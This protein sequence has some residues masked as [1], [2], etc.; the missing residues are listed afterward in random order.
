MNGSLAVAEVMQRTFCM[1]SQSGEPVGTCFTVEHGGNTY[2]VTAAHVFQVGAHG[3]HVVLQRRTA[4]REYEPWRLPYELVDISQEHDMAVVQIEPHDAPRLPLADMGGLVLG[5]QCQFFGFPFGLA[6]WPGTTKGIHPFNTVPF[7]KGATLASFDLEQKILVLDG[8]N[9]RG[10]SGGPVVLRK[11]AREH[12]VVVGVVC[13]YRQIP[14]VVKVG[15]LTGENARTTAGKPLVY[16]Q[17]TGLVLCSA[18]SVA[19]DMI[20][21]AS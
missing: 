3:G 6:T 2:L 8:I 19:L 14:D 5:S 16:A 17:N 15:S 20:E 13:A 11:R 12:V 9:N 7:V 10:F 1:A 4:K 18:A 21:S